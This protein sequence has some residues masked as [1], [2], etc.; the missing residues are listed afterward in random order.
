M[1][2]GENM[3]RVFYIFFVALCVSFANV[4]FAGGGGD[5]AAADTGKP[6]QS[7]GALTEQQPAAQESGGK[8][9]EHAERGSKTV[10]VAR[11]NAVDITMRSLINLMNA[12]NARQGKAD[13]TA[14]E[15]NTLRKKALDR[16]V[17]EELAYQEATAD[18]IKADP[19]EVEKDLQDLKIKLGGPEGFKEQLEKD[20]ATEEEVRA[21]IARTKVLQSIFQK[22]IYDKATV[23]DDEI[24][25]AY[26]KGK[27]NKFTIAE[28]VEVDDI[29]FFLDPEKE[30][31]LQKAQKVLMMVKNSSDKDPR[32]LVPDGT[33]IVKKGELIKKAEPQLYDEAK[34]LK[35]G[36]FSGVIQG[37]DSLHILKLEQ[38]T[39]ERQLSMEEMKGYLDS[40]LRGAAQMNRLH[41]WEKE[42]KKGAAVEIFDT[43]EGG[44]LPAQ[45]KQ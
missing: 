44:Q 15:K 2:R 43:G 5:G 41:E 24:K 34:K 39:P 3:K 31:S 28:K 14:E 18:G 30:E 35:P 21:E 10:I 4:A 42:L 16:L 32:K 6:L 20:D 40:E 8:T 13:R 1:N 29:V 36:E 11:V 12:M 38:Y 22:E 45:G 37:S 9:M 25:K 19:A 17:F 23:S 26:E 27:K 7:S 33:F